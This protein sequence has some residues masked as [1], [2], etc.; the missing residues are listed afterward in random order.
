MMSC[1]ASSDAS[2]SL[3]PMRSLRICYGR[4]DWRTRRTAARGSGP[5]DS[6]L[7]EDKARVS[8]SSCRERSVRRTLAGFPA[9]RDPDLDQGLVGRVGTIRSNPSMLM[10]GVAGARSHAARVSSEGKRQ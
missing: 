7:E 10:G 1:V 5:L 3:A 4:K 9:E 6:V 8:R 2:A